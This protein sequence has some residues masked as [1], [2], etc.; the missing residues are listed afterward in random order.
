V[1][2]LLFYSL[3][4]DQSCQAKDFF[5]LHALTFYFPEF[6][7]FAVQCAFDTETLY[8][9]PGNYPKFYSGPLADGKYL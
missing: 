6:F 3:L 7:C 2:P 1:R 9:M 8:P 4:F 5:K